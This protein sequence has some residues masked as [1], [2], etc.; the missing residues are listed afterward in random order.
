[1]GVVS[2][3][4]FMSIVYSQKSIGEVIGVAV[5][6][7]LYK[8]DDLTA[9]GTTDRR[10]EAEVR[11]RPP[12]TASYCFIITITVTVGVDPTHAPSNVNGSPTMSQARA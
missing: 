1:M 12:V 3:K 7:A 4:E 2:F 10:L 9:D 5:E 8:I 6:H 11:R